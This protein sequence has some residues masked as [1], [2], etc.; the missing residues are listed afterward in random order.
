MEVGVRTGVGCGQAGQYRA[1]EGAEGS[2]VVSKTK[3]S[4]DLGLISPKATVVRGFIL[5]TAQLRVLHTFP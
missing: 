2:K 5:T 3:R 4:R 1:E